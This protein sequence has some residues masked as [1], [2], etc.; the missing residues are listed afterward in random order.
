MNSSQ[1]TQSNIEDV[2]SVVGPLECWE[3]VQLE[4]GLE[5][6]SFIK[7]CFSVAEKQTTISRTRKWISFCAESGYRDACI[8]YAAMLYGLNPTLK[9]KGDEASLWLHHAS[10]VD[11]EKQTMR[12]QVKNKTDLTFSS[13]G[14]RARRFLTRLLL[15]GSLSKN[16]DS[17]LYQSFFRSGLRE[18]HLLPLISKYLV[19]DRLHPIESHHGS[20]KLV[21]SLVH[22]SDI[23]L[24]DCS[25][26]VSLSLIIHT[27]D[28]FLCFLP[29]ILSHLPNLY[30]LNISSKTTTTPPKINLSILHEV[31]TSNIS[32]LNITC[33]LYDSLSPLSD[34]PSLE[35]LSISRFPKHVRFHPLLGLPLSISHSLKHL[36]ISYCE[37]QDISPLSEYDLSSLETLDLKCVSPLS[38]LS[39]LRGSDLSSLLYLSIE[40]S[41]ISDLSPLSECKGFAPESLS[42]VSNL[43][44]DLSPLSLLDLSRLTTPI[45]LCK[46]KVSDLSS[47]S[48]FDLSR[49]ISHIKLRRTK[50]SDLSPLENI[51]YDGIEVDIRGTPASDTLQTA[52]GNNNMNKPHFIGKVKVIY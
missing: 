12:K 28:Q 24:S 42:L 20:D 22:I 46:T 50:V 52:L 9:H 14:S 8:V 33:C 41:N 27:D 5:R 34:I 19:E 3:R 38:D 7:E 47:L 2:L 31:D 16:Q 40:D 45:K 1:H 11:D 4:D 18:V 13:S 48:L 26:I 37:L 21:S 17:V 49:L 30:E 10:D 23:V 39:P 35:T 36:Y 25:S 6:G 32:S 44:E 15:S 43:I 29:L 51:S